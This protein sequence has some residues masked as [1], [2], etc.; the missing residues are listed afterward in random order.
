[1]LKLGIVADEISRNFRK[2][3]AMGLQAG[4]RRYEIR[5][6]ETGRAPMCDAS[7]LREIERIRDGEGLEITALSPG[8]FKWTDTPE[9]FRQ[10]MT[11][12]FPR[13][14]ELATRWQLSALIIF[15][16]CKPGATEAIA[17]T[18]HA[19]NIPNWVREALAEA[20][21]KSSQANLRLYIEPEPVCYADS[22]ASTVKL[23][24]AV[25]SPAL[26]I[27]YD[28]CNDAWMLRR[29]PLADFA[30]VAPYIRNVHIKDQLDAPVRSGMPQWVMIGEGMM[31]WHAHLVALKQIGYAGPVSLEPHFPL[32]IESLKQYK[33]K[34]MQMW[35]NL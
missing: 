32:T 13:A 10:E 2:A 21:E 30:A 19:D 9:K 17:D 14:V 16:F 20:A 23:L 18:I 28:P 29:D 24:Q 4:I 11:D 3:V 7:E 33:T 15:G 25:N 27:N 26:G 8:L 5:F 22:G 12:V 31:N 6:L 34:V 35:E 1:M